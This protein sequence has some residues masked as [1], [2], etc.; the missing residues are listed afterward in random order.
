MLHVTQAAASVLKSTVQGSDVPKDSGFRFVERPDKPGTLAVEISE[1]P[2]AGDEV[3]EESGIRI[4]LPENVAGE[5]ADRT[6]DI[7]A[8]ADGVALTIR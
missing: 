6:L 7:D 2:E 4:F 3:I 8:S 1:Q 5:L